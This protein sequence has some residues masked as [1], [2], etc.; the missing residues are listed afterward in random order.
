MLLL[1]SVAV[2]S[3]IRICNSYLIFKILAIEICKIIIFHIL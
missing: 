2:L 3:F 1:E